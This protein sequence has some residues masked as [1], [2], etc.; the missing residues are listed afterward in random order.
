MDDKDYYKLYLKYKNKYIKLKNNYEQE[1][2]ELFT[3]IFGILTI[4]TLMSPIVDELS[5]VKKF[6]SILKKRPLDKLINIFNEIVDL[7]DEKILNFIEDLDKLNNNNNN[8]IV[9]E[10]IIILNNGLIN[11]KQNYDKKL[12]NKLN[13]FNE[14][15]FSDI[16][17]IRNDLRNINTNINTNINL[18][19]T[20]INLDDTDIKLDD[21][22]KENIINYL[23]KKLFTI[24]EQQEQQ[25]QRGG[26]LFQRRQ[27]NNPETEPLLDNNEKNT[28]IFRF[29]S[30]L[31]KNKINI[32]LELLKSIK[33]N[34]QEILEK[35]KEFFIKLKNKIINDLSHCNNN[36]NLKKIILIYYLLKINNINEISKIKDIYFEFESYYKEIKNTDSEDK[37]KELNHNKYEI[38]MFN[39]FYINNNKIIFQ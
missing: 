20:N 30:F 33:N 14:Y 21:S 35:Y 11:Y 5:W 38:L 26:R 6:I 37:L 36:Y 25:E 7:S 29:L 28:K 23:D 2:G 39:T 10:Y 27:K 15:L 34:N 13:N 12:N 9:K 24:Y 16:E 31:K 22:D 17:D 3:V 4:I 1:G 32:N 18:D 19:D 8:D